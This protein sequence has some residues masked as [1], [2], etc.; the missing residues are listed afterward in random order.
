M[1]IK[2]GVMAVCLN[3]MKKTPL[4]SREEQ[5]TL[6]RGVKENCLIQHHFWPQMSE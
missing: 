5:V 2:H 4:G 6:D 3:D 1:Y